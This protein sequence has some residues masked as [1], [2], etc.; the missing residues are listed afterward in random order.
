MVHLGAFVAPFPEGQRLTSSVRAPVTAFSKTNPFAA[1]RDRQNAAIDSSALQA[2]VID[3]A[4]LPE[5][6]ALL[7]ADCNF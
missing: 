7:T 4:E 2:A 6:N 1:A 3:G 5:G